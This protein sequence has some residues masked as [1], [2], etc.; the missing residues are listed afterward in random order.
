MTEKSLIGAPSSQ[1]LPP[2]VA[3]ITET[4]TLM[5]ELVQEGLWRDAGGAAPVLSTELRAELKQSRDKDPPLPPL[6]HYGTKLAWN[7]LTQAT[8]TRTICWGLQ[9]LLGPL[10]P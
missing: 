4:A 9:P 1:S 3:A 10:P 6:R 2:K 7:E 8:H 5:G